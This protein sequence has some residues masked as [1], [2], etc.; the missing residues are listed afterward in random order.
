MVA[1]IR[2]KND[3]KVIEAEARPPNSRYSSGSIRSLGRR[4]AEQEQAC[5]DE[6]LPSWAKHPTP[7]ASAGTV[8][9]PS[10]PD[11][12]RE[13]Y[14]DP[15][16]S[17]CTASRDEPESTCE[18]RTSQQKATSQ[19]KLPTRVL[20]T[21]VWSAVPT[22]AQWRVLLV[23]MSVYGPRCPAQVCHESMRNMYEVGIQSGPP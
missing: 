16:A 17:H 21:T 23:R 4:G 11:A 15:K 18:L 2:L 14:A 8:G 9:L 20:L 10:A 6:R 7:V 3:T 22:L 12:H 19:V 5:S 1:V 13:G